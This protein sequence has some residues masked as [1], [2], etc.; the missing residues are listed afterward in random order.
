MT[1]KRPSSKS[2]KYWGRMIEYWGTDFSDRFGESPSPSWCA[3]F[4]RTDPVA[5]DKAINQLKYQTPK[6]PPKLGELEACIPRK[7]FGG[8]TRPIPERL[9]ELA[10]RRFTPCRHQMLMSWPVKQH[11]VD[12]G[13]RLGGVEFEYLTIPDCPEA[14]CSFVGVRQPGHRVT[15][16]ELN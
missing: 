3:V 4:D 10:M 14:V 8:D 7:Q 1:G 2:L 13:T 12:D 5:L 6:F 15:V 16:R 11:R 9:V